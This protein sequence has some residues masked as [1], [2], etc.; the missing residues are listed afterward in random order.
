MHTDI[1]SSLCESQR[2]GSAE[3]ACGAGYERILA[4][5][6]KCLQDHSRISLFSQDQVAAR[7]SG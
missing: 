3:S 5:E 7:E 1:G 2:D 6:T 4:I